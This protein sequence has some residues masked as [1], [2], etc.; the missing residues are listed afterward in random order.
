LRE[1]PDPP[2]WDWVVG[3][4]VASIVAAAADG[5]PV[6]VAAA[7]K[8]KPIVPAA[9]ATTAPVVMDRNRSIAARRRRT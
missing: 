5:L 2:T 9:P 3:A 7:M 6:N 1:L 8:P 4:C